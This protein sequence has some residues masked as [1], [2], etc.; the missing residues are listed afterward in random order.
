MVSNL[1]VGAQTYCS[2]N[3]TKI[4]KVAGFNYEVSSQAAPKHGI[5]TLEAFEIIPT[6]VSFSGTMTLYRMHRDGGVEAAGMIPVWEQL[7]KGKYFSITITD[8]TA[9]TV[10]LHADKCWVTGQSWRIEPKGHVVGTV[11]VIGIKYENEAIF[12]G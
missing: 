11:Q 5:D 6:S 4:A 8:K 2:I 9:D 3:S 12:K 10:L 1:I 7:T